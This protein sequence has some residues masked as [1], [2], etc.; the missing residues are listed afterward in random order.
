MF[1]T[2]IENLQIFFPSLSV[3]TSDT[4]DQFCH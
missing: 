2:F 4:G 1:E 3:I